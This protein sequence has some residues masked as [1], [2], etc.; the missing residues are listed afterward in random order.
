MDLKIDRTL[1]L[2]TEDTHDGLRV[3]YIAAGGKIY[4]IRKRVNDLN[5]FLDV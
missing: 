2:E 3:Y 5:K 1:K 4:V